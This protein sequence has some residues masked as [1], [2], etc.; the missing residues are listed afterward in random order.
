MLEFCNSALRIYP[1]SEWLWNSKGI[2]LCILK[3]YDESI[4]C[5]KKAVSINPNY[6]EAEHNLSYILGEHPPSITKSNITL[7]EKGLVQTKVHNQ[8][9][10]IETSNTIG[11]RP[12]KFTL[13]KTSI[14]DPGNPTAHM[15]SSLDGIRRRSWANR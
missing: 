13:S 3:K 7:E 1:S 4:F 9:T 8:V 14:P 12:K 15:A 6:S 10:D 2:S 11:N 5:F